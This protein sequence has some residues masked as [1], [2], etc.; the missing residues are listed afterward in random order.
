M[1]E[2]LPLAEKITKLTAVCAVCA[3]DAPYTQRLSD[4]DEVELIG[5]DDLYRPVCR[6]CF[7]EST[8]KPRKTSVT[9]SIPVNEMKSRSMR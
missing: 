3:A 2:L 8:K 1:I 7:F 4:N 9:E 5:G 6:K